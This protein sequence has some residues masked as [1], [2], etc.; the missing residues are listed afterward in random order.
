[1]AITKDDVKTA[2]D[3]GINASKV[4]LTNAG[5]AIQNF[6]D[7]SVLRIEKAQFE[8]K[9]KRDITILGELVYNKFANEG[10]ESI[11]IADEDVVTLIT[12]MKKFKDEAAHRD[13][14]LKA[15]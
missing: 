1:M 13:E 5:T 9:F 10:L 8:N 4:A 12:E 7:R 11:S 15:K 2:V 14:I 6:G 3:K